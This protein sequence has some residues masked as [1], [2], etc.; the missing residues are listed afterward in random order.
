[1]Y[2]CERDG[3]S[4]HVKSCMPKTGDALITSIESFATVAFCVFSQMPLHGSP[5]GLDD[6]CPTDTDM[7]E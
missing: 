3:D 4:R 7:S 1:M 5:T 2:I 6:R